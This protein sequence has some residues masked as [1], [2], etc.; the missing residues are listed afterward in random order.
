M[1]YNRQ[2]KRS[3]TYR[4]DIDD[5]RAM[6]KIH[7]LQSLDSGYHIYEIPDRNVPNKGAAQHWGYKFYRSEEMRDFETDEITGGTIPGLGEYQ[8]SLDWEATPHSQRLE[9]RNA[10]GGGTRI[11]GSRYVGTHDPR[12]PDDAPIDTVVPW[13]PTEIKAMH[14]GEPVPNKKDYHH[15]PPEIDAKEAR[16]M[17]QEMLRWAE[18]DGLQENRDALHEYMAECD[19]SH[20]LEDDS[21]RCYSAYCED[22]GKEWRHEQELEAEK[23]QNDELTVVGTA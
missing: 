13:T 19:H 18:R 22:C 6:R 9:M 16:E 1:S 2:Q 14:N 12:L 11:K 7:A 21:G 4:V 8:Y 15:D 23:E 5:S 10:N 17:Y 20:V 3:Y